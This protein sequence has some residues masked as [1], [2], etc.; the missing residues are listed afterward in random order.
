[1][2]LE[3]ELQ[4][5]RNEHKANRKLVDELKKQKPKKLDDLFYHAH[6][7]IFGQIDCLECANCCKTTSPPFTTSDI[8]R[9]SKHLRL[10]PGNF[11]QNFLYVDNEGDYVLKTTPCP[12]LKNNNKC[13]IYEERPSACQG[14]PHTNRKR[15]H[16]ILNLTLTNSLICP[17]VA[18]I[19]ELI[20]K[21]RK[22]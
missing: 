14:Y 16:E 17:A 21:D 13:E 10:K 11:I 2:K 19:L 22:S 9:I 7:V 6:D 20:R 15:I 18:G 4:K 12:F 8:N 1:M 5:A 3:R